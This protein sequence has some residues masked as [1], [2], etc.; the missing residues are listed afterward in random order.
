MAEIKP[1]AEV[2][3]IIGFLFTEDIEP[4]YVNGELSARC[5]RSIMHSQK[6]PFTHTDY[7]SKEMAAVIFRQW[8]A[9]EKKIL[10]GE[11]A[12]IKTFTNLVEKKY[13]N[14][15]KGRMINIDPGYISLSNLVLASTKNYSHRIYL[16]LGIYAE[17]TLI[18]KHEHFMPLEW[19]YPDYK[20]PAAIEF[21]EKVRKNFKEKRFLDSLVFLVNLVY[22]VI[23]IWS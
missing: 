6:I 19:T 16:D 3:P 17:I 18:F 8:H 2:V 5:G 9:Y 12:E 13:L 20:E 14:E 1:V 7:Y 11:L 15:N 4:D 23:G 21:F 22:L 10:P